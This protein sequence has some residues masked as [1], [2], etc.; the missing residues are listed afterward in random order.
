MINLYCDNSV[1][2]TLCMVKFLDTKK[3]LYG[4]WYMVGSLAFTMTLQRD[5]MSHNGSTS[6]RILNPKKEI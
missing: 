6:G 4:V 5:Y 1:N 2:E 3:V